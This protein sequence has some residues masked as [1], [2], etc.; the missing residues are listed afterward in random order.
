M[1]FFIDLISRTTPIFV[2]PYC[3]SPLELRESKD[4]LEE[5]LSKN[6]IRPSVSSWR[7]LVLLVKKKDDGMHLCI[8]Y[9]QLNKITI[10]NNYP[11]HKSAFTI[12]LGSSKTLK[13]II[14]GLL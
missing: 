8:D 4:Q 10:K 12:F 7:A 1:E 5:L 3:M 6:F 14:G 2:A 13:I 9:C 11:L